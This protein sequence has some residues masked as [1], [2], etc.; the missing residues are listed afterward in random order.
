MDAFSECFIYM[1]TTY[2]YYILAYNYFFI[3]LFSHFTAIYFYLSE[4][5]LSYYTH[6]SETFLY[7]N[8]F[9]PMTLMGT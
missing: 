8:F 2:I 1:F 7:S 6:C 5:L 9:Y 4:A 3:H